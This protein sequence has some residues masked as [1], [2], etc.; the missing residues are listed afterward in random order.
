MSRLASLVV[1]ATL[2]GC[3]GEDPKNPDRVWIAL[4]G[5]SE[6][7]LQLVAFEPDPY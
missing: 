3:P 7:R 1:L 6:R 4:Q 5:G 2:A